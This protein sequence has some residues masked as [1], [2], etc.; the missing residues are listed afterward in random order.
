MKHE[1][2]AF[3]KVELA[4]GGSVMMSRSSQIRKGAGMRAN[5]YIFG[6]WWEQHYGTEQFA[7]EFRYW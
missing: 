6:Y 1:Q 3:S 2:L 4:Q 5:L 7:L